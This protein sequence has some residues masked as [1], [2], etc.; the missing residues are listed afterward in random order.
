MRVALRGDG[1]GLFGLDIATAKALTALGF[2]RASSQ[3][4]KI[5]GDNAAATA[6]L[7]AATGGR[8]L[9]IAGGVLIQD[10]NGHLIGAV[11]VAGSLP[12]HDERFALAGIAASG[13]SAPA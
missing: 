11:G 5:F 12:D 1:A 13:G 4:A 2:N 8:F 7:T 3:M 10:A 6:G 9:P